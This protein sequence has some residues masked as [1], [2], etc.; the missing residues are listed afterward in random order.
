MPS[1]SV[2]HWLDG[3]GW[4]VLGG[5]GDLPKDRD[6][7]EI[8]AKTLGRASADGVAAVVHF[9]GMG[10]GD[11]LL[12][13]IEDLGAPSGYVV[14]IVAEDDQTVRARLSE[15]GIVILSGAASALEARSALRGA[16]IDGIRTAHQNGAIVLVEGIA[17]MAFGSYILTPD[18]Q[19]DEGLGWVLD[20]LIVP[21][22]VAVGQTALPVLSAHPTAVAVGIGG[23][24][25]LALGPDGEVEVWGARRISAALGSAYQASRTE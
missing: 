11:H 12:D 23:G 9:G 21:G 7:S 4:L 24:A 3:R 16:A 2:F 1:Q 13:D 25:A 8:R 17:A 19:P 20:A 10:A 18:N 5:A 14:D 6:P 22:A 15:A